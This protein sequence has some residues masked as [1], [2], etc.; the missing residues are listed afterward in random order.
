[1]L[2]I[3]LCMVF[4]VSF[5]IT[6][7]LVRFKDKVN[8][9]AEVNHR[10]IHKD[11]TPSS[12]GIAI[13]VSLSI[14]LFLLGV[15]LPLHLYLSILFLF[16]FG[17]YDD[18]TGA[19]LKH[20]VFVIFILAN[21]LFF[22]GFYIEYLGT[23]LGFPIELS[24]FFAYIFL[25]FALVGFVNAVNLIDGLDGL[26]S[27]VSLVILGSFLYLGIKWS[28]EFLTYMSCI[29]IVSILGYLYFNWSPAK[30]FMGD[31]GSLTLGFVIAIIAIYAVNKHY[32]SPIS[33]L[34]LAAVPI[35]D[36]F[37]AIIRR[38]KSGQSPFDADKEHLHHVILRA[39]KNNTIKTVLILGLTQLIFTYIGLGFKI[40]D[41]ILILFLFIMIFILVKL[42]LNQNGN[43]NEIHK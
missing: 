33:T 22:N 37:L 6:Y 30:I 21:V 27:V 41:D 26:V 32:I 40:R 25:V 15:E 23:F 20:K 38:I 10:S 9:N 35:L 19:Q 7:L 11:I 18:H 8:L 2:Y 5:G 16:L 43:L 42:L 36:T 14:G 28:D 3:N 24:G 13:F 17:L 31:N 29:Y 12:G 39:Q 4:I 1:M 34:L